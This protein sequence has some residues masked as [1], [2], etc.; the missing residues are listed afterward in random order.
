MVQ[1]IPQNYFF[2]YFYAIFCTKIHSAK[3]TAKIWEKKLRKN[4]RKKV[5]HPSSF[6][7]LQHSSLQFQMLDVPNWAFTVGLFTISLSQA[8][9]QLR[10]DREDNKHCL[11]VK[12]LCGQ[13]DSKKW[14][15]LRIRVAKCQIF[16]TDQFFPNEFTPRKSAYI[17]TNCR[18]K[19][20]EMGKE[21]KFKG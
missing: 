8:G 15:W 6:N 21:G 19:M 2:A 4:K 20:H 7:Q 13:F 1:K 11:A 5:R 3:N 10:V 12:C 17:V 18:L 16:Y 9:Q 14:K